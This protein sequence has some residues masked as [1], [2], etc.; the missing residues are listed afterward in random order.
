MGTIGLL[1]GSVGLFLAASFAVAGV[2]T[3]ERLVAGAAFTLPALA[4]FAIGDR[5]GRRFSVDGFRKAVLVLLVVLGGAMIHRAVT[6][7]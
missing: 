6:A 4:G 7:G 5:L 2:L 1:M 3:A